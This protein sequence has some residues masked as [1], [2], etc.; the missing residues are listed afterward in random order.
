MPLVSVGFPR[1]EPTK[2]SFPLTGGLDGW[3]FRRGFPGFKSR[4]DVVGSLVSACKGNWAQEPWVG[5]SEGNT[6][7]QAYMAGPL[8]DLVPFI[9]AFWELP[10]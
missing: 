9:E 8:E 4:E 1:K 6:L 5:P 7:P 2:L 3:W 10:C